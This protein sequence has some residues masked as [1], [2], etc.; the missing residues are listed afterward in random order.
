[1]PGAGCWVPVLHLSLLCASAS[2]RLCDS[3]FPTHP[4]NLLNYSTLLQP[5]TFSNIEPQTIS[6][7]RFKLYLSFFILVILNFSHFPHFI[8]PL[9]TISAK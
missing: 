4:L 7:I 6:K 8:L 3:F 5:Q 2:L 9:Q 1:V